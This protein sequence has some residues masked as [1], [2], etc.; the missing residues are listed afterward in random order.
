MP[1]A[2]FALRPRG[3]PHS[4]LP[5]RKSPCLSWEVL[6]PKI[7]P[8]KAINKNSIQ[9]L[10]HALY[11]HHDQQYWRSPSAYI[12]RGRERC[13]YTRREVSGYSGWPFERSLALASPSP[14]RR[15]AATCSKTAEGA[16]GL[17]QNKIWEVRLKRHVRQSRNT[18]AAAAVL[19]GS[20]MVV[21]I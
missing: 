20:F 5:G 2:N 16:F 4:Y 10:S 6:S 18:F 21:E 1:M 11:S 3:P 17:W 13:L 12:R 14:P 19:Q 7:I 9:K 8:L 15:S